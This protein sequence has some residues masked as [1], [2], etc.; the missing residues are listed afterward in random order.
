MTLKETV[1]Y[2]LIKDKDIPFIKNA[3][4]VYDML[5][6]VNGNGFYWKDG[7]LINDNIDITFPIYD[8]V[9]CA[10]VDAF[11]DFTPKD[12]L[13]T[14]ITYKFEFYPLCKYSKLCN[15]PDNIK[16]GWF[17]GI[18]KMVELIETHTECI[19]PHDYAETM[20]WLEVVKN[21]I[22]NHIMNNK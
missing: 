16:P 11:N 20:K 17:E 13:L 15:F 1:L 2:Y 14:Y 5:F 18:K 4:D 22:S 12:T 6:C 19:N 10:V 9:D 3:L 8:Y 21:K 7:E